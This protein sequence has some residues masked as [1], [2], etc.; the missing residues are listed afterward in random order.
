MAVDLTRSFG[1]F[2]F[3]DAALSV[4]YAPFMLF[5]IGRNNQDKYNGPVLI[6]EKDF[7]HKVDEAQKA[8]D[9]YNFKKLM[10][11]NPYKK[12]AFREWVESI[13]FAVFAAAFI[14]MFLIEAYM[15]PTSTMEGSLLV[16]DHLFVSKAHYGIRTP[17]TVIQI[18]LLHNRIPK[19]NKESYISKPNLPYFRFPAFEKIRHNAPV[20]FNYPDGDSVLVMPERSFS[21]QDLKRTKDFNEAALLN[22][23]TIRPMDKKDHYIKRCI[24]LPGDTLQIIDRQVFLNGKQADNPQYLQYT[25]QVS[26]ETGAINL[27][28][29]QDWGVNLRDQNS[30]MG[31]FNLNESQVE[32][33]KSLGPDIKVEVMS[34]NPPMKDYYFPHDATNFGDW[35]A[36]NYG[37]IYIPKKGATT[38]INATNIALFR[39]IIGV[40][41][42]NKLEERDGKIYINDQ[43]SDQ[44]TFRMDYYWMMGDNRHNSEDSRVWGFVP[45][46]HIVG[47]PLFIWMSSKNARYGD[48]IRWNRVFTS[49]NKM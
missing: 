36:D 25:Y 12:S 9:D 38:T 49:A 24:G 5:L 14:R 8:K 31:Y 32:K 41:E 23:L 4:I 7:F 10:D 37:P 18:P 42:G 6:Q 34:I 46:D 48:G 33:I 29:L 16:G 40:Y 19:I 28:K 26:S 13:V 47:K 17:L 30:S 21:F 27:S 2:S 35:S 45:E 1:R 39:R 11:N 20:V 22:N 15:I 3:A 43:E 44:Y